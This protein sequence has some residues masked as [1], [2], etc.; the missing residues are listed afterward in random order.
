M[1]LKNG[2][3]K[4][5]PVDGFE[6]LTKREHFAGLAMQGLVS[7]LTI[8]RELHTELITEISVKY[9]DKLLEALEKPDETWKEE[10][11]D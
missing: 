5:F 4:V 1:E 6:G 11:S 9:A 7:S 8:G 2:D 3:L 10:I